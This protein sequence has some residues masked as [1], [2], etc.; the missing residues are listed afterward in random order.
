MTDFIIIVMAIFGFSVL[1]SWT[2]NGFSMGVFISAISIS[3]CVLI[4]QGVLP[5][6][7]FVAPILI[8]VAMLVGDRL[9]R[10]EAVDE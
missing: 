5:F 9:G 3:M 1:C 7:M 10:Q 8:T 2:R 6:Y 4:W